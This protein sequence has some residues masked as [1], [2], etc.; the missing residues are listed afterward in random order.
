MNTKGVRKRLQKRKAHKLRGTPVLQHQIPQAIDCDVENLSLQME[1]DDQECEQIIEVI[2]LEGERIAVQQQEQAAPNPGR[3]QRNVETAHVE[4]DLSLSMALVPEDDL[5]HSVVHVQNSGGTWHPKLAIQQQEQGTS[6]ECEPVETTHRESGV[7]FSIP[8]V[9]H[10][11]DGDAQHPNLALQQRINEVANQE[12]EQQSP[13]TV[14]SESSLSLSMALVPYH[15]DPQHLRPTMQQQERN[16]VNRGR[17]QQHTMEVTNP[18]REG[19]AA[20]HTEQVA[21]N[22][23][24]K[25]EVANRDREVWLGTSVYQPLALVQWGQETADQNED[26]ALAISVGS[27]LTLGCKKSNQQQTQAQVTAES[28]EA[29]VRKHVNRL[30]GR[31]CTDAPLEPASMEAI[32]NYKSTLNEE[33]GPS[34]EHFQADFSEKSL[35]NSAWNRRLCDLFID[36]YVKQGL[37]FTTVMNVSVFF[38]TYLET[39]QTANRKMA[40]TVEQARVYKE[41]SQ[42]N[43]IEKRKKTVGLHTFKR[44]DADI[45]GMIYQQFDTQISALH[46]YKISRFIKPLEEISRA[47]LSDDKSDHEQGTHR[48]QSH[49]SIRYQRDK[50][51]VQPPVDLAFSEEEKQL[52][53]QFIPLAKGDAC[54]VSQD[55]VDIN[56]LENWLLHGRPENC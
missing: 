32:L 31:K 42:R 35:E 47:A 25:M 16:A 18:E 40:A 22:L 46:Y 10:C 9:P 39:L 17:E 8:L 11:G 28:R 30:M 20:Q 43:M 6:Q 19:L 13:D 53:A 50:L 37:L 54:P 1:V 33:D 29:A 55:V 12:R 26:G 56:T 44:V 24:H 2:D 51:D 48:G 15:S 3:K 23:G 38:M 36:N 5:S 41:A 27:V 45:V 4:C 52:A 34:T 7:S 21:T 14:S 49:Y